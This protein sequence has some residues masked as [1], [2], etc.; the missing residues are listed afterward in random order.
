MCWQN[1]A[2]TIFETVG[3]DLASNLKK[4]SVASGDLPDETANPAILI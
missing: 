3:L 4:S 2:K 1:P